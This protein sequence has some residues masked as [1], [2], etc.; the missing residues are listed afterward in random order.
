M[1]NEKQ[2]QN[3]SIKKYSLWVLISFQFGSLVSNMVGYTF[4]AQMQYYYETVVLIDIGLY[5]LAFLIYT[6]WNM[7]NDP[8]IGYLC[9]RSTRWTKK[10]GKRFPFI[11]FFG[12]TW[13][14]SFAL[15]F[16]APSTA[17]IGQLGVFFW[18]LI[19]IILYDTLGSGWGVNVSG[20]FPDKF[21]DDKQRKKSGAIMATLATIGLMIG[22]I[23]PAIVVPLFGNEM[24]Y[25]IMAVIMSII[26]LIFILGTIP[27]IREDV[28]MRERRSLLDEK[29]RPS[30]FKSLKSALKHK[31]FIIYIIYNLLYALFY[32]VAVASIPF[33]VADML[34]LSKI[35]EMIMMSGIILAQPL[36]AP[37]WYKIVLKIGSKKTLII[38]NTMM[39][40]GL[41][42]LLFVLNDPSGA[43]LTVFSMI[44]VGIG[45]GGRLMAVYPIWSDVIDEAVVNNEKREEG[46]YQ[47]IVAFITRLSIAGQVVIFFLVRMFSGYTAGS[48]SQSIEALFGLRMQTVIIPLII[49]LLA[50]FILWKGFDLT[51]DKVKE[52]KVELE[53]K[54]L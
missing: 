54:E 48:S 23:M 51:P 11:I 26:A 37:I 20:L 31:N 29:K 14:I 19:S 22:A 41:L 38:G 27:G 45:G 46:L 5:T 4:I 32:A 40:L 13:S 24:G 47:G 43:L 6:V 52:L 15:V 9:D 10:W 25:G 44:L 39:G 1:K 12:I 7:I 30:F 16:M 17:T 3:T 53:N 42:P 33:W 2:S 18:L 35:W 21:R 28:E 50:S 49:M 34:G 36:T 8:L